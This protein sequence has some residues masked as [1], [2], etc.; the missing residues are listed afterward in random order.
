M[1]WFAFYKNPEKT[2]GAAIPSYTSADEQELAEHYADDVLFDAITFGDVYKR[3]I[4]SVLVPLEEFVLEE[5]FYK[6][7]V[8]VGDSFHKVGTSNAFHRVLSLIPVSCIHSPA[9]E[10]TLQLNPLQ[11]WPTCSKEY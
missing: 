2:I 4:N 8:L 3:R 10:E 9:R 11:C 7:A 5:C 6:R 1:Y